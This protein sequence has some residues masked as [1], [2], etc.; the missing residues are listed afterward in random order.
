MSILAR[1]RNSTTAS[2]TI[3]LS[4]VSVYGNLIVTQIWTKANG[5]KPLKDRVEDVDVKSRTKITATSRKLSKAGFL[6][7]TDLVIL[8]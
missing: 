5:K 2:S 4:Q 3:L 1:Q 8:I 7:I 6:T